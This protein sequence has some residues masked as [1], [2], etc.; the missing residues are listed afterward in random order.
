MI[1]RHLKDTVKYV[2]CVNAGSNKK[3]QNGMVYPLE[4]EGIDY[5]DIRINGIFEG[6]FYKHRF[7]FLKPT[8]EK[9][10]IKD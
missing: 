8:N 5:V 2:K 6:G 9:L 1:T 3:L 10:I 4:S 7:E